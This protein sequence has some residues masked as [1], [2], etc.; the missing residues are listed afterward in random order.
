[1]GMPIALTRLSASDTRMTEPKLH[2]QARLWLT[3]TSTD[4]RRAIE[5]EAARLRTDVDE[6]VAALESA[7]S[8]NDKQ[9]EQVAAAPKPPN[10]WRKKRSRRLV[11]DGGQQRSRWRRSERV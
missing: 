1:M 3:A 5:Q 9:L 2:Q 10:R 4:L 7:A 8:A 11:R 6:R